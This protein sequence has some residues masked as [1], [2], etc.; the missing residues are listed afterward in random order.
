[1]CPGTHWL[2]LHSGRMRFEIPE[3]LAVYSYSTLSAFRVIV[4]HATR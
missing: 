4:T 2:M 3:A 1:M